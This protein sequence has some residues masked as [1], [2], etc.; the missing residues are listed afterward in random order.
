MGDECEPGDWPAGFLAADEEAIANQGLVEVDAEPGDLLSLVLWQFREVHYET[1]P[2]QM[3]VEHALNDTRHLPQ[4][5]R[6]QALDFA[7]GKLDTIYYPKTESWVLRNLT[8]NEF[9]QG[10]GLVT[11]FHESKNQGGLHLGYPGFGEVVLCRICW[12]TNLA[13]YLPSGI[14]RGVWAGNRFDICTEKHH[15]LDSN[16]NWKNVTSEIVNELSVALKLEVRTKKRKR[17]D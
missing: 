14:N 7:L 1:K 12:S 11:A 10:D 4:S 6:S 17:A 15:A 2:Y 5:K 16:S 13:S 3:L 8:T 9:V